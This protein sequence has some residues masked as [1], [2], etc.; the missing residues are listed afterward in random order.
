MT[1][2]IEFKYQIDSIETFNRIL[3]D[4][5]VASNIVPLTYETLAMNAIYFDTDD[6]ILHRS[7]IAMR[8]RQEGEKIILTVKGKGKSNSG[9]YEREELNLDISRYI[10]TANLHS[11]PVN[12]G[13]IISEECYEYVI[14][15]FSYFKGFKDM[16]IVIK[17]AIKNPTLEGILKFD[18]TRRRVILKCQD[19]VLELSCDFGNVVAGKSVGNI[20]E[21]EIELKAGSVEELKRI[22]NYIAQKYDL[23]AKNESKLCQGLKLIDKN[24]C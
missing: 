19:T 3:K 11:S 7:G 16:S 20:S 9:Q 2:E 6:M 23:E 21:M 5:K 4:E 10:E 18:F 15:E 24:Q 14:K 1:I 12:R 17:S 13:Q 8:I 22:G